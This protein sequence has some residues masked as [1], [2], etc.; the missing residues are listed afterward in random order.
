MREKFVEALRYR[1]EHNCPAGSSQR[2][3]VVT[4]KCQVLGLD[5]EGSA[6]PLF[7]GSTENVAE[8]PPQNATVSLSMHMAHL[9]V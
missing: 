8:V 3:H 4:R 6:N 9:L 7:A 2:I 1:L 5:K